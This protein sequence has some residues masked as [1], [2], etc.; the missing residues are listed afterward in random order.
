MKTYVQ[1]RLVHKCS[2]QQ[3][4]LYLKSRNNPNICQWLNEIKW[5]IF[6]QWDI[7]S[8]KNVLIHAIGWMSLGNM[9]GERRQL[10]KG[11]YCTIPFVGIECPA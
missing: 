11:T 6:I 9:L 3:D 5:G 1:I 2:E 8:H 7:V 4:V 10:Q